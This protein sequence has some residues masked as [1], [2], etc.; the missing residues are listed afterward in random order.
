MPACRAITPESPVGSSRRW[1]LFIPPMGQS[2]RR[3]SLSWRHQGHRA[4][5]RCEPPWQPPAGRWLPVAPSTAAASKRCGATHRER[6]A[7]TLAARAAIRDRRRRRRGSPTSCARATVR[8]TA[9]S[10]AIAGERQRR[11][12]PDRPADRRA[13]RAARRRSCCRTSR[14]APPDAA[15]RRARPRRQLRDDRRTRQRRAV[16]R[17]RPSLDRDGRAA[18]A[19]ARAARRSAVARRARAAAVDR[20]AGAQRDAVPRTTVPQW[21]SASGVGRRALQLIDRA[22]T[23]RARASRSCTCT[24]RRARRQAA[25]NPQPPARLPDVSCFRDVPTFLAVTERRDAPQ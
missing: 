12:A 6:R 10:I 5:G 19:G 2:A 24:V 8:S 1:E 17:L 22:R 3:L 13:A 11:G 21:P 14:C 7:S 16:G 23:R 20:F 4:R 15:A 25:S 9:S 18:H